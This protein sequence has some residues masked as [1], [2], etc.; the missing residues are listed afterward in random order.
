M[1]TVSFIIIFLIGFII[2]CVITNLLSYFINKRKEEKQDAIVND[3]DVLFYYLTY[4]GDKLINIEE[5]LTVIKFVINE[6]DTHKYK[7]YGIRIILKNNNMI[8]NEVFDTESERDDQYH[9]IYKIVNQ[10][11]I[12]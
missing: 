11:P 12:Y 6:D 4:D 9:I 7:T 5:I 10:L 3:N 8:I 2:G 1:S